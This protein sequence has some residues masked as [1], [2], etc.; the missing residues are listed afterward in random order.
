MPF[1]IYVCYFTNHGMY[2]MKIRYMVAFETSDAQRDVVSSS[3][4]S[5]MHG[6]LR[7]FW[8]LNK[9]RKVKNFG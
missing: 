4:P 2:I 9:I 5:I 8:V 1:V 7:K 6:L 3:S